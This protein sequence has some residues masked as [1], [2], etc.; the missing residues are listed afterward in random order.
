[1][2]KRKYYKISFEALSRDCGLRSYDDGYEDDC[3]NGEVCD[4]AWGLAYKDY[5]CREKN[6][7]KLK[8][9]E[10]LVS[11]PIGPGQH[12]RGYMALCPGFHEKKGK[13]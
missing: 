6:C 8:R 10:Q 9:M 13:K 12:G 7:P 11:L 2:S 3:Y 1:M 5:S 4:L